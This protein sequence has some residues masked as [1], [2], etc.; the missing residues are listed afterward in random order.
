MPENVTFRH[1][2]LNEAYSRAAA[3]GREIEVPR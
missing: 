2:A 3:Y 1:R